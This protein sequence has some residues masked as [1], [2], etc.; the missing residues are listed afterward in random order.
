MT[1]DEVRI[2][3]VGCGRLAEAG[4]VPAAAR[5]DGVRVVAVADTDADRRGRVATSASGPGG[6]VEAFADAITLLQGAAV[7]AVVLA[8]P[9]PTHLADATAVVAAGL[10][11]L[12][13]KPPAVDATEAA[14]LV[15]LG[16]LV[17]T[18]FNRRFD[19]GARAVRSAL[20]ATGDLHLDLE[21][22][23]RRASWGAHV[24]RDEVLVD[25]A[26][27]LVDWAR[28][29]TGSEITTVTATA[30]EPD[31]AELVLAL[32]RGRAALVASADAIHRERI[33]VRDASGQRVARHRVGGL[34]A[35]IAGRLGAGRGAHPLEDSL[36]EQ[37]AAFARI[38]RGE[39]D[40]V[41][42]TADD[43]LAVMEVVDAA[44][45]SAAAGGRPEPVPEHAEDP[46]C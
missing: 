45:R 4:Y 35:G 14:A 30:I 36:A 2:G 15:A 38:V 28:W 34:V 20:P 27:H 22:G 6:T 9:A 3:L 31:R 42:G 29:L 10:P 5:V 12:V 44:R 43:G 21:L 32:S 33:E 26:P 17:R 16:P 8:T 19:P 1:V 40:G 23:Y 11:V 39:H 41:L 24:V 18:G 46:P 25:L 13:E 7:D 37:L